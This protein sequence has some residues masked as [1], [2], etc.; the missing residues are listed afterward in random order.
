MGRI[1]RHGKMRLVQ[2]ADD[3]DNFVE[4]KKLAK[5]AR[6]SGLTVDKFAKY[7]K[8]YLYLQHK[9]AKTNSQT[10]RVY[11]GN[12]FIWKGKNTFVTAHPIPYRYIKE[13]EMIDNNG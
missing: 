10:I 13:M 2:R 9:N 4:A 7:P 12:I 1:T 8:F 3:C 5:L 6:T 11:R